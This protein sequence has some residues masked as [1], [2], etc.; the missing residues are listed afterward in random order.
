MHRLFH[1]TTGYLRFMLATLLAG[2]AV[3][4]LAGL[5]IT[6]PKT[7]AIVIVIGIA[8]ALV[9]R[10][11]LRSLRRA[12]EISQR[13]RANPHSRSEAAAELAAFGEGLAAA[14]GPIVLFTHSQT[15]E[16]PAKIE[17][18]LISQWNFNR[19]PKS[20]PNAR[21]D[22]K[23]RDEAETDLV[24]KYLEAH[25]KE[26]ARIGVYPFFVSKAPS[27]QIIQAMRER[28]ST[29]GWGDIVFT[30]H[31]SSKPEQTISIG[32]LSVSA[33]SWPEQLEMIMQGT[34]RVVR[35]DVLEVTKS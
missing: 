6:Q 29:R 3:F 15:I 16:A 19:A 27:Q 34:F 35:G 9:V 26:L 1:V 17:S 18:L 20:D 5:A 21:L 10:M 33:R 31:G 8:A 25:R 23:A 7:F 13:N 12:R 30:H 11:E 24:V 32:F 4:F 2:T 22:D 28:P 14:Y